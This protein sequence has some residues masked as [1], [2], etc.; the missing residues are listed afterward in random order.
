ME[1]KKTSNKFSP[2]VR[3][4]AVRLV[5]E[6]QSDH[7]SQWIATQSFTVRIGCSGGTLRNSF[8]KPNEIA[9]N[10][11]DRQWMIGRV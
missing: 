3:A 5:H 7:P 11:R 1:T 8:G 9:G 10:A 4:R 6:H 2:E